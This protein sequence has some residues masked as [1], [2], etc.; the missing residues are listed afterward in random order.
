M[1]DDPRL[2][3]LERLAVSRERIRQTLAESNAHDKATADAPPSAL[4]S[5]FLAIPG[6]GV[7]I[8]AVRHW[9]AQ[10]P[11][12]FA[13]TV[14]G[15]ATRT[16]VGP[17]ARRNPFTLVL[18]AMAAG[19]LLVWLKPWRGILK[20]ALLAGLMPQIVSR[21]IAHVPLESWLSALTQMTT[22]RATQ[23][24]SPDAPVATPPAPP[25]SQAAPQHVDP[26][27]TAPP[28][29]TTLH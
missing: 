9:W 3:A 10:H 25:S 5:A 6:A 1:N 4:M 18:L 22:Q 2:P 17:M 7:V 29:S 20:P 15:H 14:A 12:H 19:G 8:D 26:A 11:M 21:A 13:G 28:S 27:S 24:G 16:L 23:A